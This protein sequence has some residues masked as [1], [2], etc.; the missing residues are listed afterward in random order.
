MLW[1]VLFMA[2]VAMLTLAFVPDLSI[3]RSLRLFGAQH[4][5]VCTKP[6]WNCSVRPDA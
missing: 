5:H 4:D 6:I 2:T 3:P 1:I